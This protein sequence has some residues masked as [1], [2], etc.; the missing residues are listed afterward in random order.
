MRPCPKPSSRWDGHRWVPW[1]RRHVNAF[2]CIGVVICAAVVI[3]AVVLVAAARLSGASA[4]APASSMPADPPRIKYLGVYEPGAPGSYL[5]I[6]RFASAVGRQPD[7][8]SS[9][10]WPGRLVT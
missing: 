5:G 2:I 9:I 1:V 10:S 7:L 3:C 8:V 4:G 6:Q